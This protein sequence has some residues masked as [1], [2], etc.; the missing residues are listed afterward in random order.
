MTTHKLTGAAISDQ[1][2]QKVQF[3]SLSSKNQSGTWS[4]FWSVVFFRD[5]KCCFIA[6]VVNGKGTGANRFMSR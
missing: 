5:T 2:Y 6:T 1:L 4:F 3:Y